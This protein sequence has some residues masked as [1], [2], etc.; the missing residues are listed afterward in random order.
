MIQKRNSSKCGGVSQL[1]I[2]MFITGVIALAAISLIIINGGTSLDNIRKIG[3]QN[4]KL[5]HTIDHKVRS[6]KLKSCPK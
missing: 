5:N 6:V 2:W 1:F 3:V 4:H